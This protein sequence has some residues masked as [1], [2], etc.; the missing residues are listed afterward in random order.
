MCPPV[1]ANARFSFVEAKARVR[2]MG[3]EE[4]FAF[5]HRGMGKFRHSSP[6]FCRGGFHI[7][8]NNKEIYRFSSKGAA[9][10]EARRVSDEETSALEMVPQRLSQNAILSR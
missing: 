2:P 9:A 7:R 1:T 5:L 8:P 3:N 4:N 10:K 6:F